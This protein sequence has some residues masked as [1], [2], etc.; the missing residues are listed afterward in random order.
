MGKVVAV[1]LMVLGLGMV[2]MG[3][4]LWEPMLE[5]AWEFGGLAGTA[6]FFLLLFGGGFVFI[7]VAIIWLRKPGTLDP[8]E[9]YRVN[10]PDLG[11]NND[12]NDYR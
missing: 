3:I 11:G 5:H 1:I 7:I 12:G 4:V 6:G 2:T 10:A 9:G 8:Y